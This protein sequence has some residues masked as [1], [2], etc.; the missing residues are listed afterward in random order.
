MIS[1]ERVGRQAE[2]LETREKANAIQRR[3]LEAAAR[4]LRSRDELVDRLCN[5]GI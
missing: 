2:R 4:R 5:D 3:T 1:G